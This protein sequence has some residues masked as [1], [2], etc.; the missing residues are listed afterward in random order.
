MKTLDGGIKSDLIDE[1]TSHI[2]IDDILWESPMKNQQVWFINKFGANVNL[3]N[4]L[5]DEIIPLES[6]RLGLR[7]DTFNLF[8]N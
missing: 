6:L 3:G 1:I 5:Y 8:L 7:G 2:N 4:I